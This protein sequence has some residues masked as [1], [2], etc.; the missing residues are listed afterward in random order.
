[1]TEYH[2]GEE[3]AK[4]AN[5]SSVE[6]SGEIVLSRQAFAEIPAKA[7][8]HEHTGIQNFYRGAYYRCRPNS[9]AQSPARAIQELVQAWKALRK[10]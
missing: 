1:M 2:M 9:A 5:L 6:E 8:D 7:R 3:T 4:C 10:G